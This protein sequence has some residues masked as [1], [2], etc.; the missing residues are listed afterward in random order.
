MLSSVAETM[1]NERTRQIKRSL[2][3]FHKLPKLS[4]ERWQVG[5]FSLRKGNNLCILHKNH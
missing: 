3:E 1:N 5:K 2:K 4:F